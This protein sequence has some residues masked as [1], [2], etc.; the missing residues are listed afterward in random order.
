MLDVEELI[1]LENSIRDELDNN[2]TTVLTNLNRCGQLEE[3]LRLLGMEYLLKNDGGYHTF[4]NGKIIII[5]QSKVKA[6]VIL[7]IAQELGIDKN[8]FEL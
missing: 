3:F 5:G 2:L 4:K 1:H 6:N 7:K 8:R